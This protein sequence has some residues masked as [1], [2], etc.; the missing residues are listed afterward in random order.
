MTTLKEVAERAGVSSA[1]VSKVISNTPY[2]SAATRERVLRAIDELGY[3]PNLAGRALASGR[4]Y[5]IGVIFPFIYTSLFADVQVTTILEGVEAAASE[6]GYNLLISSPPLPVQDSELYRRFVRSRYFD[7]VI[8][9]ENLP[10]ELLSSF[11][12]QHNYPFVTLGHQTAQSCSGSVHLDDYGGAYAAAQHLVA[13]GHRR[14]GVIGIGPISTFF[15]GERMRGYRDA[16]TA[17]GLSM[18]D[19]PQVFG[20]Y[21]IASGEEAME[22]LLALSPRP[23]AVLCLNDLMAVGAMRVA[24]Q[25][26][27]R[28]PD[29]ISFVGFDDIPIAGYIDPP[30]TTVR[31]PSH[32][33][34]YRA[35]CMLFD[36]VEKKQAAFDPVTVPAS[37]IVR[38]SSGPAKANSD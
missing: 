20:A 4:T 33:I 31:Q 38:G 2:V 16:L 18:D 23:T 27:L 24:Q 37:L 10:D 5:N 25:A 7:G 19:M 3:T 28:I 8:V 26:G 35:A 30:L 12:A 11:V 29:D 15:I 6:R 36:L 17:A 14:L 34:G 13:L 9:L 32:E 21:S 22:K 1:T